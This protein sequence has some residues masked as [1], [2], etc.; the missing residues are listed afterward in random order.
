MSPEE[1]TASA[2]RVCRSAAGGKQPT[3]G[4]LTGDSHR[5]DVLLPMTLEP[6]LRG[7]APQPTRRRGRTG[8]RIR[9][10]RLRGARD[11]RREQE[12]RAMPQPGQNLKG[13]GPRS[14]SS[15]LGAFRSSCGHPFLQGSSLHRRSLKGVR[16]EPVPSFSPPCHLPQVQNRGPPQKPVPLRFAPPGKKKASICFFL[17]GTPPA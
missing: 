17:P 9:R 2:P 15:P 14:D 4:L 5:T 1:T 11:I 13:R 8:A 7:P 6:Q 16:P 3:E 12:S 10:V